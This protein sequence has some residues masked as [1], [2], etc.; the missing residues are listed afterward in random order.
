[1]FP[2]FI[3]GPYQAQACFWPAVRFNCIYLFLRDH[4]ELFQTFPCLSDN[5]AYSGELKASF[6]FNGFE[7]LLAFLVPDRTHCLFR[8]EDL[9]FGS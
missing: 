5:F 1:M 3:S 9:G 8:L 4:I 2:V 6:G 7:L